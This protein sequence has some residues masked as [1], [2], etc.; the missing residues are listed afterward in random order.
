MGTGDHVIH[1][2]CTGEK[3][4]LVH[5][6]R[7]RLLIG[8]TLGSLALGGGVELLGRYL[9]SVFNAS[10]TITGT[11]SLIAIVIAC[12]PS[13]YV[14]HRLHTAP[15]IVR[16]VTS[17]AALIIGSQVVSMADLV[18]V[19]FISPLV[20]WANHL[21]SLEDV[22]L[23]TGAFL[24][25][26]GFYLSIFHNARITEHL[27]AERAQLVAEIEERR[28]TEAAFRESENKYRSL[29]E[30]FPYG[31]LIVQ[32]GR[33]V[34]SNPAASE[35]L[36]LAADTLTGS[37]PLQCVAASERERLR[38]Y[39]AARFTGDPSVPNAYE[40]L[41]RRKNGE[42]F[43]ALLYV[44]MMTFGGRPAEQIVA[45]DI[46][47]QKRTEAALRQTY[48]EVEDRVRERTARLAETNQRLETEIRER[49]H[50][51]TALRRSE[52]WY[53]SL[54]EAAHEVIYIV[55][56]DDTVLYA[57]SEAGRQ[58]DIP[59]AQ[60]IGRRRG[61][62][63][64]SHI[65][66]SQRTSLNRVFESGAP[67]RLEHPA[68]FHGQPSWQD[69]FLVPLY[70]ESGAIVSVMGVSRDITAR[71]TAEE[72][73]QDR[74]AMEEL[75]SGIAA[76]LVEA[77]PED[78][79]N[80]IAR[81]LKSIG[82]FIDA[83]RCYIVYYDADGFYISRANEWN[84]PGI[85]VEAPSL[86]GTDV[87]AMKWAADLLR[88]NHIVLVN[89]TDSMPA[90]TEAER[91]LLRRRGVRATLGI[92]LQSRDH[93]YGYLSMDMCRHER[94]WAERDMRLLLLVANIFV[95][96]FDRAHARLQ[97]ENNERKYRTLLES[98]RDTVYRVSL[99]DGTFEYIS[100]SA[101][102]VFGYPAEAFMQ[103]PMFLRQIIHPD[104]TKAFDELWRE[105]LAG[106]TYGTYEYKVIDAEDQERWI[107]QSSA[108]IF[109]EHGVPVATEGLCRNITADHV[110]QRVIE[111]Q[112]AKLIES[113]KMSIL[114][115]M[116]ANIAHEIN[117]PLAIVSGSA[118]QLKKA[119]DIGILTPH[120]GAQL[121]D[122]I[123][124][125]SVRI[126]TIVKGLR[127]LTRDS[128][129]EPFR[130]THVK[131]IIEDTEAVCRERFASYDVAL[132][133]DAA[134]ESLHVECQPT[135]IMEVL[136]NL[137]SNAL[138]A[139][140]YAQERWV[141]LGVQDLGDDVEF[142]VMDSGPGISA[143]LEH[144][145]FERFATTK[146]FGKGTGLGLNISKRIMQSHAGR[147]YYDR[148]SIHTRFAVRLPKRVPA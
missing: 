140:E 147:I 51:E 70:D 138:H 71:K 114:G 99:A 144:A 39:M 128:S 11:C 95:G 1:S 125:N 4:L 27:A 53:R 62:L 105:A 127:D 116:A 137:L 52:H 75:V 91:A 77:L 107:F 98:L 64:P 24:L 7:H 26:A 18:P 17:G 143:E 94:H 101:Y 54:A 126:Q 15:W 58:L 90:E 25:S 38:G 145:L 33:V 66:Q 50:V 82:Q 108:I 133:V 120:M 28:H 55:A 59:P 61:D 85:A 121:S 86:V 10:Y 139:V 29:V 8:V 83:D 72:A 14:F 136:V 106:K 124:R 68:I 23:I 146:E 41:I 113:Q 132:Q 2:D 112:R 89:S 9:Y 35:G 110:A 92:A 20:A 37:D 21:L 103:T 6:A 31:I 104:F 45:V 119:L 42:E 43:H 78:L 131:S 13:I 102:D 142:S 57:N 84:A 135:Q 93:A 40:A 46:S 100:P 76:R 80:E 97:L 12:V 69:T 117:N 65:A 73:L 67:L 87:T 148:Q 109:D 22:L 81:S 47:T 36:V 60:I 32:D 56:Q 123:M 19:P 44:Q 63:F 88:N 16:T 79:D 30:S 5:T 141:S 96:A 118:E 49:A 74:L 48:A 129:H 34:F 111:E 134:P 122:T 115:E 3:A 130:M